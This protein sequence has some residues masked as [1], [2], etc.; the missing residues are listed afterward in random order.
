MI[1]RCITCLAVAAVVALSG[2]AT[3][4]SPPEAP[5]TAASGTASAPAAAAAAAPASPRIDP[6]ERWNRK[7][8]AFNDAL[9][10][11]VIR[12]VAEAYVKVV[13]QPIRTGV[14]NFY[15]NF[16]DA[17]SAVNNLLQGKVASSAR[18]VARVG[19]NTLIGLG[20]LF[21]VATPLGIDAQRE[22][23]GQT[24]GRWGVPPGPYLVL[25]FFGPSNVRDTFAMP[26]DRSAG[27]AL[28]FQQDSA[29]FGIVLVGLV[30]ERANLLATGRMLDDMAL[31]RYVFVRDAYLQRRRSQVY[32]GN[33]PSDADEFEPDAPAAAAGASSEPA[34]PAMPAAAVP[35]AQAS[36]ALPT[37]PASAASAGR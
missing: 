30:N 2:C 3:T 4:A 25:P 6:W 17:W 29:R 35:A 14:S 37:A 23:F 5:A 32:D 13:P 31:D 8:Y 28:A 10:T 11:A 24:L 21:D 34:K 9:D 19:T 1:V 16:A 15:G 20:G 36:A 26:L 12:P 22:D 27:P 7:V 18:D 33:E